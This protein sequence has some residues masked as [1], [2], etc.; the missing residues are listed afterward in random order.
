MKYD[1]KQVGRIQLV[2]EVGGNVGPWERKV[3]KKL[4]ELAC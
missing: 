4:S 2:Y 3:S 1:G